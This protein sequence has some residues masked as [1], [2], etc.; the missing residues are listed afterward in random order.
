MSGSRCK[1]LYWCSPGVLCGACLQSRAGTESRSSSPCRAPCPEAARSAA[2]ASRCAPHIGA[3]WGLSWG[4]A[5]P[6]GTRQIVPVCAVGWGRVLWRGWGFQ[7][8]GVPIGWPLLLVD[9]T[10]HTPPFPTRPLWAH[11]CMLMDGSAFTRWGI[12]AG[13]AGGGGVACASPHHWTPLFVVWPGG[14]AC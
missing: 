9:A 7:P 2:R 3:L 14:C 12:R 8:V 1:S 10:T 6:V 13:W 4:C 11:S 5:R